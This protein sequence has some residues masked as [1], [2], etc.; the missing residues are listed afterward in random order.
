MKVWITLSPER[1]KIPVSQ[2]AGS[3]EI[4]KGTEGRAPRRGK[5]AD[6]P[7]GIWKI[8]VKIGRQQEPLTFLLSL[9]FHSTFT[10]PS[11]WFHF[12]FTSSLAF[13]ITNNVSSLFRMFYSPSPSLLRMSSLYLTSLSS[14]SYSY[15]TRTSAFFATLE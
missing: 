7:K 9:C 12:A 10:S 13:S 14:L 3:L 5:L 4:G 2:F 15:T 11:F 1:W 8:L 6:Q